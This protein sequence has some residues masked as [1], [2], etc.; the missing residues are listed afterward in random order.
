MKCRY[1][2]FILQCS[3]SGIGLLNKHNRYKSVDRLYVYDNSIDFAESKLL[4]RVSN[5]KLTKKYDSIN[6]WALPIFRE[7]W[8][9]KFLNLNCMAK[10]IGGW[11]SSSKL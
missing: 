9:I 7:L 2:L 11:V 6:D 3:D 8:K 1:S 4:F 10:L 5:G